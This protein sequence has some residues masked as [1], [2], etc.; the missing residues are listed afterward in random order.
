MKTL[1]GFAVPEI[2]KKPGKVYCP[3]IPATIVIGKYA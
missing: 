3:P 2:F 1:N